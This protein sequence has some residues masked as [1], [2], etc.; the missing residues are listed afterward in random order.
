MIPLVARPAVE[1][2]GDS[3]P[4]ASPPRNRS[5]GAT[6]SRFPAT[7]LRDSSA[8][9]DSRSAILRCLPLREDLR[10]VQLHSYLLRLLCLLRPGVPQRDR[11]DED[12]LMAG[13]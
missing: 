13:R 6:R 5:A 4:C 2:S 8:T 11:A 1:C 7:H 10:V 12:E 9:D 3:A